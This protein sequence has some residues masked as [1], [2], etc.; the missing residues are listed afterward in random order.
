MLQCD[1]YLCKYY[2][3]YLVLEFANPFQVK[4]EFPTRTEVKNKVIVCIGFKIEMHCHNI[5]LL[6]LISCIFK[7]IL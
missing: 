2:T 4:E 5:T 6:L 1:Y 3:C 7:Q